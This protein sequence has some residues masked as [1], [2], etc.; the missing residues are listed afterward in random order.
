M[1]TRTKEVGE[2]CYVTVFTRGR[3]CIVNLEINKKKNL[4][5]FKIK[6]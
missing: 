6:R 1:L 2:T 4:K 3:I 5:K